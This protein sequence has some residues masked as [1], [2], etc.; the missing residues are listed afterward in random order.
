M[1]VEGG[2][3]DQ[4]ATWIDAMVIVEAEFGRI[5]KVMMDEAKKKS[6]KDRKGLTHGRTKGTRGRRSR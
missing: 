2:F 4:V 3:S 1:P 6:E 5:Q